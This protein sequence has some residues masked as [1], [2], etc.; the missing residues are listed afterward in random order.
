MQQEAAVP[1]A[2]VQAACGKGLK[3]GVAGH[4]AWCAGAGPLWAR[5]RRETRPPNGCG[6]VDGALVGEV[7]GE[8]ASRRN[9]KRRCAKKEPLVSGPEIVPCITRVRQVSL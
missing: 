9:D 6:E 7:V 8:L 2:L 1:C 4:S 3:T 5:R